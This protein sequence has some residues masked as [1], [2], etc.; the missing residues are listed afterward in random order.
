MS[1]NN[2]SLQFNLYIFKEIHKNVLS[3]STTVRD[4][5]INTSE[6]ECSACL[7]SCSLAHNVPK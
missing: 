4:E 2:K 3:D 7:R 1:C 5:K 6:H